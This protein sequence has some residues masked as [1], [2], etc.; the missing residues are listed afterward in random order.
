MDL[1]EMELP[2]PCLPACPLLQESWD[3]AGMSA[4]APMGG[5]SAGED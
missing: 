3:A 4:Q 1:S 5:E 2:D